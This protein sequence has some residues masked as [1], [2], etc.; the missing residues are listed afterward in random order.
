LIKQKFF[1]IVFLLSALAGAFSAYNANKT[2]PPEQISDVIER[3]L[4]GIFLQV[5]LRAAEILEHLKSGDAALTSRDKFVIL[6][7]GQLITWGD[8]HAIPPVRL[9]T[10]DFETKFIHT[11]SIDGV[12][13]K[14]KVGDDKFLVAFIPLHTEYKISN[15]Y[16]TPYWNDD[17]FPFHSLALIDPSADQGYPVQIKKKTLFKV[18]P[19]P[20]AGNHNKPWSALAVFFFVVSLLIGLRLAWKAIQGIQFRYPIAAF[21]TLSGIVVFVRFVMIAAEF[22]ARFIDSP[23]FDPKNFASSGWNPSIGDLFLN[24]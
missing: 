19:I 11:G 17:V 6:D 9:L 21:L 8:H 15:E 18:L 7:H 5:D 16:L 2:T 1:F 20:G 13:R 22:P 10:E 12:A 24:A 3:N 23:L 4:T 14:W